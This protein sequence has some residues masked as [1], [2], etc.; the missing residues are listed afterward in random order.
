VYPQHAH[1]PDA[2]DISERINEMLLCLRTSVTVPCS[3]FT[4][5]WRTSWSARYIEVALSHQRF[6]GI[7]ATSAQLRG[8]G[9]RLGSIGRGFK[10]LR[11]HQK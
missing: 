3:H 2:T 11:T 1:N 7:S 10:S 5:T 6:G 9:F 4:H 8:N